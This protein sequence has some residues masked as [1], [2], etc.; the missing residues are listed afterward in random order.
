MGKRRNTNKAKA[1][2]LFS[3]GG[4]LER[5]Y[6]QIISIAALTVVFSERKDIMKHWKKAL[7]SFFVFISFTTSCIALAYATL[8]INGTRTTY[9]HANSTFSVPYLINIHDPDVSYRYKNLT[10]QSSS[11]TL[12]V[13]TYGYQIRWY[14]ILSPSKYEIGSQNANGLNATNHNTWYTTIYNNTGCSSAQEL[15]D[16]FG[17]NMDEAY[18]L[19]FKYVV[20][21]NNEKY[22]QN[23]YGDWE[24]TVS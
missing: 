16:R 2:N 9:I 7:V 18:S 10:C 19:E 11:A 4:V 5:I 6:L 23:N 14:N 8:S 22:I 20:S 3:E 12:V 24:I 21:N 15:E 13:K 17:M 1:N